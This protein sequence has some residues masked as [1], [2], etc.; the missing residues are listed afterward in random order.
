MEVFITTQR[1]VRTRTVVG[2]KRYAYK[3]ENLH[4]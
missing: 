3:K 1:K 4:D 2:Y